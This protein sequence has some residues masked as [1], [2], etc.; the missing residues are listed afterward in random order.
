MSLLGG[1]NDVTLTIKA[2]D[3]ASAGINSVLGSVGKLAGGFAVGQLAVSGLRAGFSFLSREISSTISAFAEAEKVNAQ[4]EAVIRS[5]GGAAGMTA[6]AVRDL[7]SSLQSQTTYTDEAIQSAENLLLTFTNITND[8]FPDATKV[9]LDMSTALGQ[10]TKASAI[11]LGKALQDPI[12]GVNALRRV[13]VN[14]TQAQQD[15]IAKLVDTGKAGEAQRMIIAELSK[16]FGGSAVAAANT[17][18]GKVEQMKNKMD[19]FKESIGAGVTPVLGNLITTISEVAS[20]M[21]GTTNV[22][23]AAF[24]AFRL[25]AEGAFAATNMLVQLGSGL[26]AAGVNIAK[27]TDKLNF[28]NGNRDQEYDKQLTAVGKFANGSSEAFQ[29]FVNANTEV[30]YALQKTS[31][32]SEKTSKAGIAAL[33]NFS[34]SAK[35]TA[36]DTAESYNKLGEAL[37]KVR[38]T[39]AD[40]LAS[41]AKSHEESVKTSTERISELRKNLRDLSDS[42]AQTGAE[43]A[44][45]FSSQQA[46]D[47]KDIGEAIVAQQQ[48]IADLRKQAGTEIDPQKR[49]NIEAELKKEQ[50][51][52]VA[53]AEF[54]KTMDVEV[55]EA[56]RRAGLSEFE[57][58]IEDYKAKRAQAEIE[59]AEKRADAA[60]EYAA[61]VTEL[62]QQTE[63]EKKKMA[64]ENERYMTAQASIT[65][66][67]AQAEAMR[68]NTTKSSAE[69]VIKLVDAQIEKYNRL[70]EAIQRATQGKGAQVNVASAPITSR[71]HG[72]IVPGAVGTA[73][74]ILA[75]GQETIVPAGQSR[76]SMS[77]GGGITVNINNPSIR[78][79]GDLNA[80][81]QMIEDAFRDVSRVHKLTTI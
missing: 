43:A 63:L 66:I 37:T 58:Q 22:T 25:F 28:F 49:I 38:Q 55:I 18:A 42:Y 47:A 24:K 13:G 21:V 72:G 45:A 36:K 69:Q 77:E 27:F 79:D 40:D 26:A 51:A 68:L 71:E 6:E 7:A 50:A 62:R 44:K 60:R 15:V 33:G 39:G 48:K 76:S 9:V 54:I 31:E 11:Q 2:K 35:K 5:T 30:S 53:S 78:S 34:T 3:E 19:D 74:P 67:L 12:E 56:K 57:R 1:D 64:E 8:I 46:N 20:N 23:M 29:K 4:T 52:Y 81:R 61:R 32:Q 80:M 70:A 73:V 14:F 41:L 59:Y 10:D 65:K 16:E 75:H 17:Y